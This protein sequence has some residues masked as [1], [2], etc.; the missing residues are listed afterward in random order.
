MAIPYI[1]PPRQMN[2]L[3][4]DFDWSS[5]RR[6]TRVVYKSR[7]D[8]GLKLI[9]RVILIHD[10]SLV[11]LFLL[12][13]TCDK[14][15][16]VSHSFRLCR[17][18]AK[19]MHGNVEITSSTLNLCRRL[20]R[21][22]RWRPEGRLSTTSSGRVS[23]LDTL[24]C[25]TLRHYSFIPYSD[26]STLDTLDCTTLRHYSFIPYSDLRILFSAA[27]VLGYYRNKDCRSRI[28]QR[29]IWWPQ[30]AYNTCFIWRVRLR[31]R[32]QSPQMLADK[33]QI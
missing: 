12:D 18:L 7:V 20:D 25:T 8:D 2:D 13:F 33:M 21:S 14:G 11:S 17:E 30:A 22:R 31:A 23:T 3:E 29:E 16:T 15:M 10:K 1:G 24:D 28:V 9:T 27:S 32:V 4:N 5:F 6:W 19:D 26:L